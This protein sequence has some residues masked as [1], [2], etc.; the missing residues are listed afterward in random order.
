MVNSNERIGSFTND[1]HGYSIL[2]GST[3]LTIVPIG[4]VDVVGRPG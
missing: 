3:L 4:H 2:A 1:C